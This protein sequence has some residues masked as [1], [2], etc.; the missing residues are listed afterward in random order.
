MVQQQM[1]LFQ[2]TPSRYPLCKFPSHFSDWVAAV[3]RPFWRHY[4]T[5][6]QSEKQSILRLVEV[7]HNL[8]DCHLRSSYDCAKRIIGRY[9]RTTTL[10]VLMHLMM[11]V[12]AMF[13]QMIIC[14]FS[15]IRAE[16]LQCATF[17]FLHNHL[18]RKC[19]LSASNPGD[20]PSLGG[21][22]CAACWVHFFPFCWF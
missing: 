4:G 17:V 11:S 10:S 2:S 6:S 21:H 1:N 15:Q 13:R 14:A 8:I 7:K 5:G 18:A 9:G 22:I 19:A 12:K 16:H 3:H 20:S